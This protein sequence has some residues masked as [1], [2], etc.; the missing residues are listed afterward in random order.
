MDL[1]IDDRGKYFTPRVSKES[2]AAALRTTEH[3]I[4]GQI[5]VRP[6]QRLKDELNL[7]Q[8]RFIAITDARVYDSLGAN[9]LFESAF[10][11]VA[12]SHIIFITPLD[13]VEQDRQLPWLP[14]PGEEG[15]A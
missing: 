15:A 11:I 6:D 4:V 13:A 10:L 12:S 2:I 5:H 1:R 3:L 9:V 7:S 14:T 8:E